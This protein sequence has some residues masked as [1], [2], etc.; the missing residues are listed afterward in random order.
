MTARGRDEGCRRGF[1][2]CSPALAL[3]IELDVGRRAVQCSACCVKQRNLL[4]SL[5]QSIVSAAR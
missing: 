5:W 1:V 3:M 4:G 2:R